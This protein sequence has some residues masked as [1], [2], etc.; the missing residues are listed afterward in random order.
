MTRVAL[1]GGDV[2]ITRIVAEELRAHPAIASCEIRSADELA[3]FDLAVYLGP[4]LGER[5]RPPESAK[6]DFEKI[7]RSAIT[8]TLIV[9]S[10]RVSPARHVHPGM[11]L[12]V[13]RL[14]R[15]VNALCDA[16][17]DFESM[18]TEILGEEGRVILRP[19]PTPSRD[20]HDYFS[21]LLRGR[22][23]LSVAGFDPP[24]QLLDA[25]DLGRASTL[26]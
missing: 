18:S 25:G 6:D 2:E 17:A 3:G 13:N 7:A 4:S 5:G 11:V 26:R 21:R 16:W 14:P 22:I 8:R 20:G 19:A 10:A 1:L 24:I 23:G 9:S 12:E 15:G